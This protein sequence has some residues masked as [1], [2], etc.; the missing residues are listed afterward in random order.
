MANLMSTPKFMA[1]T[2]HMSNRESVS[3]L[4]EHL[5]TEMT[6]EPKGNKILYNGVT[7]DVH[8]HFSTTC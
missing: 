7:E 6:W 8:R 3:Y 1:K 4:W 5:A 2:R